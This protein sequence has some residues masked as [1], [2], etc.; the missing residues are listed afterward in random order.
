MFVLNKA[1]KG[2]FKKKEKFKKLVNGEISFKLLRQ[3]V[4]HVMFLSIFKCNY[5]TMWF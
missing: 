5:D 2:F 1:N 4:Q 3:V